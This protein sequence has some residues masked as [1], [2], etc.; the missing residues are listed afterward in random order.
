[1]TQRAEIRFAQPADI[2]PICRL[3][4]SSLVPAQFWRR[5]LAYSW[6]A[7]E[8]KPDLGAVIVAGSEIVGFLGA[9]YSNRSIAGKPERFCNVFGWYVKPDYRHYSVPLLSFLV[10]RPGLTFFN[11]TP[12]DHVLPI[13]KRIGFTLADESRY[14]CRPGFDA[15]LGRRSKVRIMRE[16]DVN[17]DLLGSMQFQIFQDH[18]GHSVRRFVFT[19]ARDVC[20]IF[21]KRMY[22]S[23]VRFPRTEFYYASNP[24]FFA[25]HFQSILPLLLRRDKTVALHIDQRHLGFRPKRAQSISAVAMY[26]SA[27][28]ARSESVPMSAIDRLY[29]ELVI[30]P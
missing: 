8:D 4:G 14:V 3:M 25:R 7:V 9:M 16:E 18:F 11:V 27:M 30:L 28:L 15:L 13:F 17:E 2:E 1:M 21:T 29:S 23:Q 19:A 5:M 24:E 20:M 10:R 6:L 12:A 22:W 26:P